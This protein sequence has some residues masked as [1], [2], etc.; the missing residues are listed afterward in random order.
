MTERVV[1]VQRFIAASPAAI[2]DV[3]ADPTRH[4][5]IDGS[6]TVKATHGRTPERLSLGAKFGMD[7]R[8]GVP[9][10]VRNTVVEFEEDRLIAWRH[11]GKHIW[12]YRLEPVDGGTDVTEEFDYRKALSPWF[13]ELM[14][15]PKR[16]EPEMERTLGRLADAVTT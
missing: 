7:M 12:R 2:F 11:V 14:G 15:Y 9:Y 5:E 8:L 1:V 13:I 3:L 16:N 10:R 6:G 4:P